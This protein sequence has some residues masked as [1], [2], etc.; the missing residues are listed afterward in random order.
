[1][2]RQTAEAMGEP[3]PP[4]PACGGQLLWYHRV[5]NS[6]EAFGCAEC[7]AFTKSIHGIRYKPTEEARARVERNLMDNDA[8]KAERAKQ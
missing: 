7:L 6:H 5:V 2:D 1:M 3:L 4:C 8:A